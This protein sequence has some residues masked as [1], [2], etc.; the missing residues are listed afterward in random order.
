MVLIFFIKTVAKPHVKKLTVSQ[1]IEH[2]RDNVQDRFYI[3]EI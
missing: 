2:S 1:F 3:E